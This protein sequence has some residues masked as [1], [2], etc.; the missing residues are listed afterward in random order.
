MGSEFLL[1]FQLKLALLLRLIL[2]I[3]FFDFSSCLE[4]LFIVFQQL[5]V[6]RFLLLNGFEDIDL[7]FGVLI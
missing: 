2:S 7:T 4:V 1:P 5:I 6:L 3:F